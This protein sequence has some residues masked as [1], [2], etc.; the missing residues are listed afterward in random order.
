MA[1]SVRC[2]YSLA[3][4]HVCGLAH[5]FMYSSSYSIASPHGK[6]RYQWVTSN[7]KSCRY[8]LGSLVQAIDFRLLIFFG[9]RLCFSPLPF[10]STHE[11]K[12]NS[13]ATSILVP[14]QQEGPPIPI[15]GPK[16]KGQRGHTRNACRALLYRTVQVSDRHSSYHTPLGCVGSEEANWDNYR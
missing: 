5:I 2:L 16:A 3:V 6:T 11:L 9:C 12:R 14:Q 8:A 4:A 15:H 7:D 10:P 1:P 13:R